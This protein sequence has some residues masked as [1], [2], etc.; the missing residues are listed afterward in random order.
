MTIASDVCILTAQVAR[1]CVCD[2]KK[3]L[4][5]N[6]IT[7]IGA[8]RAQLA[9]YCNNKWSLQIPEYIYSVWVT[10]GDVIEYVTTEL[11]SKK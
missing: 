11:D 6:E 5:L 9:M 2:M 10:V 8:R 7:V 4:E 1:M 3:S